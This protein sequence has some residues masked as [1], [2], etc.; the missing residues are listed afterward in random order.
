MIK[1]RKSYSPDCFFFFFKFKERSKPFNY[2]L[3]VTNGLETSTECSEAA[4]VTL[5]KEVRGR[6]RDREGSRGFLDYPM[7]YSS[8]LGVAYRDQ[9]SWDN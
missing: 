8:H 3:I 7:S 2:A 5:E 1:L 9:T 6:N 4:T